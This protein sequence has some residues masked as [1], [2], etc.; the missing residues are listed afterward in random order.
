M[1]KAGL[2]FNKKDE[3]FTPKKIVDYFGPFD[4]DPATT[5]ERAEYLGIKYFDTIETNGLTREWNQF[6]RIWINP[7]F[8]RKFDFLKKAVNTVEWSNVHIFFLLPIDSMVTKQ[9]ADIMGGIDYTL[10]LPNK[11]INFEDEN[12][13]GSSPAFGSVVIELGDWNGQIITHWRPYERR[14]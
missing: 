8:T 9:F 5:K 6:D 10:Y 12:G 13:G 4:Y 2:Q 14:D 11:R 7:P 3:W 1:A